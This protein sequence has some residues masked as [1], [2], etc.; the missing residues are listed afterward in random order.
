M[1]TSRTQL[2]SKLEEYGSIHNWD[3][4]VDQI[5]MF[6]Y[7]GMTKEQVA[8]IADEHSVYLTADGRI[9][10]AGVSSTNVAYLANAMH[11]VTK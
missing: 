1:K 7:T 2:K 10:I 11:E 6:C 9:S 4:V 3:H 8:R 5:G